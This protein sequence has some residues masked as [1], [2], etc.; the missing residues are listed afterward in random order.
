MPRNRTFVVVLG[1]LMS[2]PVAC[3]GFDFDPLDPGTGGAGGGG[4]KPGG[5]GGRARQGGGGGTTHAGGGAP[6]TGGGGVRPATGGG[7]P[8]G[9]GG[10]G[11][12]GAATGGGSSVAGGGGGTSS[13]GGSGGGGGMG[14]TGGGADAGATKSA[15]CGKKPTLQSGKKTIQSGGKSRSYIL[16]LPATYDENQ[17][18]RLVFGFH[19]NG[20]TAEDVDGGGSSGFTWS[21]YGL[22]EQSGNSTI[23]VAPQGEGNGW[24]NSG[25]KDLKLVDDLLALIEGDLC[26][27][28]SRIFAL[29]FSY[30]GG[31]SYAIAC[32]RAKVFRAVAVY[33]G[34]QLSG[35]E[36]GTEPIAYLG[37]HSISDGTCNIEG[38]R[39]LRDKFVE[40]NG[41]TK[42]NPPEPTSSG[43]NHIV[44]SYA[45]C[46]PGYPVTWAAFNGGGHTPAPVDGSSSGSGTGDKTWTK[47]ETWKFFSQF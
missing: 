45:G 15:G 1:A 36:G 40:N 29:G 26:I 21:Y 4:S 7:G 43:N 9:T 22:R 6:G 34:A 23:Y 41:C 2:L 44:T 19:W 38:G 27:D 5:G 37:I 3:G 17:P 18:H 32:G 25:G 46:K 30:G 8:S 20:G 39:R 16:R 10:S 11:S 47:A 42:Q 35:C 28:Q 33:S 31:M 14:G 12:G 13:G 24:A